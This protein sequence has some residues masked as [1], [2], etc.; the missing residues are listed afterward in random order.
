MSWLCTLSRHGAG[1]WLCTL[2]QQGVSAGAG[3]SWLWA[4]GE[5]V[6]VCYELALRAF[7][8]GE[9]VGCLQGR[10]YAE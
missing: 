2:L 1:R 4:L 7:E 3:I 9:L 10:V 5:G 8:T 6:S